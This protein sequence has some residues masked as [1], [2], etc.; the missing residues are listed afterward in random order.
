MS[1]YNDLSLLRDLNKCLIT[2][3]QSLSRRRPS[4]VGRSS[5]SSAAGLEPCFQSLSSSKTSSSRNSLYATDSAD[6]QS[7]DP[8]V[9]CKL[10]T[11]TNAP[12]RP[13][14]DGKGDISILAAST[15]TASP[16]KPTLTSILGALKKKNAGFAE[17]KTDTLAAPPTLQSQVSSK[18]PTV[19]AVPSPK[20]VISGRTF[21]K[22]PADVALESHSTSTPGTVTASSKPLSS[23]P[24]APKKTLRSMGSSS[25]KGSF[26]KSKSF[27]RYM[28]G[29]RRPSSTSAPLLTQAVLCAQRHPSP[30]PERRGSATGSQVAVVFRPVGKM[31]PVTMRK[32]AF[33]P[34]TQPLS[35]LD[36]RKE[37]AL[38]RPTIALP[39][40]E[41]SALS[42]WS[43]G[44]SRTLSS[45]P[46]SSPRVQWSI[47][48]TP[49]EEIPFLNS[50]D[51]EIPG[52][53]RSP[54]TELPDLVV[55]AEKADQA[56]TQ[57]SVDGEVSQR[58]HRRTAS[59]SSSTP[60]GSPKA[61]ISLPR[62]VSQ[63]SGEE[64]YHTADESLE[65]S[66]WQEPVH[67]LICVFLQSQKINIT[68]KLNF[69][70]VQCK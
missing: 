44:E 65:D 12:V 70:A 26:D 4:P 40:C 33:H 50:E 18:P 38:Q 22:D 51:P 69:D 42:G 1:Q 15:D 14:A 24:P 8:F 35:T 66:K 47:E 28:D 23:K 57:R 9:D 43:S 10:S 2:F 60:Y 25:S 37:A 55:P 13:N 31:S 34:T 29:V 52:C 61:Q 21:T 3:R 56:V 63:K 16:Q 46:V 27:E 39:H 64:D 20:G 7:D 59:G 45:P 54:R 58:G 32:S 49:E 48:S 62:M 41:F 68:G 19:P 67:A 36:P 6:Q 5:S 53:P 17:T 30:R 11:S